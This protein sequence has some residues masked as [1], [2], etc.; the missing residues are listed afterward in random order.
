MH[1]AFGIPTECCH[2]LKDGH[3]GLTVKNFKI[4]VKLGKLPSLRVVCNLLSD[5]GFNCKVHSNFVIAREKYVNTVFTSGHVNITGIKN[6]DNIADS[7]SCICKGFD[8]DE[9]LYQSK[10]DNI[11][12]TACTVHKLNLHKIYNQALKKHLTNSETYSFRLNLEVFPALYYK[13]L[14]CTCIIFATGSII[15]VGC[16]NLFTVHKEIHNLCR[17]LNAFEL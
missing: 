5:R 2:I 1:T 15:I 10:V 4:S 8:L 17:I 16:K 11:S 9:A 12:A 7:V 13:S 14:A 6:I 3:A